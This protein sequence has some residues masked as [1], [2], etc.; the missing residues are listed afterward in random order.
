MLDVVE[1]ASGHFGEM[2]FVP[3]AQRVG[4]CHSPLPAKPGETDPRIGRLPR[5]DP[6]R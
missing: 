6:A 1:K 5:R 2:P 3:D 4:N